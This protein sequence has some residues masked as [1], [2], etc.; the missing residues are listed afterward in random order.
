MTYPIKQFDFSPI[1]GW[2]F[3]RY[4]TFSTCKR[5]YFYQYYGK[6]DSEYPVLKIEALKEMTS[7]P[8]EIGSIVHDLIRDALN[9]IA[10]SEKSPTIDNLMA[11]FEKS[12]SKYFS[13][14]YS[15]VYYGELSHISESEDEIREKVKMALSNF[16]ASPRLQWIL[17]KAIPYRERWIVEP[18]G[19]GETRINGLK[20]YCKVDFLFPVDGEIFIVDWK[21]GKKRDD[22]STQLLGY[23]SW[24]SYHLKH[25]VSKIKTIVAY[26]IPEYQEEEVT[27][28][29]FDFTNFSRQ[30][31]IETQQLYEYTDN[32]EENVP[33]AKENFPLAESDMMCKYCNFREL[34]GRQK[35]A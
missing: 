19:Y 21:T 14:K 6:Y 22:H 28:D 32:I 16:L 5:Q 8:L 29:Q 24:A 23:A 4:N 30:V 10:E 27:F 35:S 1:L 18:P 31:R 15:E 26:L 33:K 2:S 9:F 25:D 13:K 34:C 17:E 12:K 3:S 11:R 20:A 7:I